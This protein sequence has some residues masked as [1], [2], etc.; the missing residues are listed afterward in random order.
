MYENSTMV[1]YEIP[2]QFTVDL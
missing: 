1:L 2:V